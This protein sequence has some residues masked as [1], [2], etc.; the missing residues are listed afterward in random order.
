MNHTPVN[1]DDSK[2]EQ[3]LWDEFIVN[4]P[5][6]RKEFAEA[7]DKKINSEINK[8]KRYRI[9]FTV[10]FCIFT[11]YVILERLLWI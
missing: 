1:L 2:R 6:L 11:L 4:H 8:N 9:A 7:I 3:E 10:L 5:V